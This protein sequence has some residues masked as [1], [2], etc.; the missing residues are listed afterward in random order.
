MRTST[1]LLLLF[2]LTACHDEPLSGSSLPLPP[3][4]VPL[5]GSEVI[6]MEPIRL[7]LVHVP[8]GEF[9]MGADPAKIPWALDQEMPEHSLFLPDFYIS[10]YEITNEQY[11]VF[12]RATGHDAPFYRQEDTSHFEDWRSGETR[13]DRWKDGMA[14]L[15]RENYPVTKVSWRDAVA[16]TQWLS[17][18]TG[19]KFQLPSEAEWE[20]AC[21]GTDSRIFPWGDDLDYRREKAGHVIIAPAPVGSW[22]K[23]AS[24]YGV[25]DMAGN[26]E[27][28]TRSLIMNDAGYYHYGYP[29]DPTDGRE[30]QRRPRNHYRA[31]R[32]GDYYHTGAG[33]YL[34]CTQRG[35]INVTFHTYETIGF[36]VVVSP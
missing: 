20:K 16:F 27:E 34:R 24:P 11:S 10:K 7:E 3:T 30:D 28:W 23:D 21:R 9:L 33:R 25:M 36:R 6:I 2:V 8:G 17:Q 32:G 14:P 12:V 19:R 31:T 26:V 15:G 22:P 1:L 5:S 13:F 29:Y 4:P 18:E 35:G